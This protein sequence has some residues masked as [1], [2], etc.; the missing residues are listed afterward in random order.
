MKYENWGFKLK[1]FDEMKYENWV[2][3]LKLIEG[4]N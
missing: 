4:I 3:N 2:F 1:S